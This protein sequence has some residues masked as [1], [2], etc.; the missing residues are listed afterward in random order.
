M[1]QWKITVE[2]PKSAK[3]LLIEIG[4][5]VLKTCNAPKEID[6]VVYKYNL[7]NKLHEEVAKLSEETARQALEEIK[8]GLETWKSN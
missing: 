6:L 3:P 7:I 1:S 5:K 2:I 4:E 8:K